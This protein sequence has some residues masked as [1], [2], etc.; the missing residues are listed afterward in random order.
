MLSWFHK[1]H[2]GSKGRRR[3]AGHSRGQ[4]GGQ[5]A[6]QPLGFQSSPPAYAD[7]DFV[8]ERVH[9][10]LGSVPVVS[11]HVPELS[12]STAA[13]ISCLSVI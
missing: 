3:A 11:P 8:P 12:R 10:A 13:F 6:R 5:G 7:L 9:R 2:R 4:S 1:R